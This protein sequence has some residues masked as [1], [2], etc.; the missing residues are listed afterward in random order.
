MRKLI[1]PIII[2]LVLSCSSD[3]RAERSGSASVIA[4]VTGTTQ[5]VAAVAPELCALEIS[6]KGATRDSTVS[7]NFTGFAVQDSKIEWLLNGIP[8][9][10]LSPSQLKLS[11]AKKGDTIQARAL[12]RGREILS[13]KIDIVNALPEIT[14]LKFLTEVVKP[15][16]VL[17]VAVGGSDV[18]EDK[19]TYL[20][21]W[22]I[23]GEPAGTESKIGRPVKRGD[24][25]V[26]KVTPFDGESY[27]KTVTLSREIQN[28]PPVI[29]EHAE[30]QFDGTRY[31]YQVK[32]SDPDGDALT[33]ALDSSAD[34]MTIDKSGGLITWIVPTAFKGKRSVSIDVT[35]GHG[36]ISRY[37]LNIAIQ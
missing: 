7:L 18:D 37:V 14:A 36:G 16:D 5:Q 13:N 17:S 22:T 11:Q 32:A 27:G 21:E 33:Y 24:S 15:G 31:T 28:L 1:Y 2:L 6:P 12:V 30:F 19:V 29:Q 23:N 25:V 9:E 4:G 34:G 35:D 10:C 8:V 3:K 20:Y 26:V